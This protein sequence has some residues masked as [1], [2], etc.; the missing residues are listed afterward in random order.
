MPSYGR[1]DDDI[2]RQ[3]F[4]S[5]LFNGTSYKF[6]W[7]HIFV[8][9]VVIFPYISIFILF[10]IS[11]GAETIKVSF[12]LKISFLISYFFISFSNQNYYDAGFSISTD[13]GQVS[14]ATQTGVPLSFNSEGK[15]VEG[16]GT[17][18]YLNTL[19][20]KLEENCPKF[21]SLAT[22]YHGNVLLSSYSIGSSSSSSLS[23]TT[24]KSKLQTYVTSSE[25]TQSV[26][27]MTS[28]KSSLTL[29]NLDIL[30]VLSVPS[31][32]SDTVSVDGIFVTL[33][34]SDSTDEVL[35]NGFLTVGRIIKDQNYN[36]DYS[37][38]KSL[39]YSEDKTVSPSLIYLTTNK[40]LLSYYK[41][42]KKTR[43]N[44]KGIRNL[45]EDEEEAVFCIK[46]GEISS[47]DFS[48]TLSNEFEIF[49]LPYTSSNSIKFSYSLTKFSSSYLSLSYYDQ[50]K[51]QIISN[52]I[53]FSEEN[54]QILNYSDE[55][56]I[57]ID[58][59]TLQS[60]LQSTF[61]QANSL[62]LTFSSKNMIQ[63]QVVYFLENGTSEISL[64]FGS[65]LSISSYFPN[66][67]INYNQFSLFSLSGQGDFIILFPD[68]S[69][70]ET[71]SF[72]GELG[73]NNQLR[74]LAPNVDLSGST[75]S[76]TSP[77]SLSISSYNK[78]SYS[79]AS[80]ASISSTYLSSRTAI[81]SFLSNTDC[82]IESE[83]KF[84]VLDRLSGVVGLTTTFF[85]DGKSTI[86]VS[87]SGIVSKIE[88]KLESGKK[89][90]SNSRGEL[91]SSEDFYG[92][93]SEVIYDKESNS[94]LLEENV[95]GIATSD[96][97]LDVSLFKGRVAY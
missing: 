51:L 74:R 9:A 10:A 37:V 54:L 85:K 21:T 69:S 6:K 83:A 64:L 70:S 1:I 91:I 81:L 30:Q 57:K 43:N 76:L 50:S 39:S 72:L 90:Y 67:N 31:V 78:N 75:Y 19:N 27:S 44:Q 82:T 71:I 42:I 62:L 17:S 14:P 33:S 55:S 93:T 49:T 68:S 65:F 92:R 16:G 88:K 4:I 60:P 11:G 12:Y 59:I 25:K 22:L 36:I 34:T 94:V 46:F 48:L 53:K 15:L 35:T 95:V 63:S 26:S 87:V 24:S 32:S 29:D 38:D 79:T 96:S 40:I 13:F 97:E 89:Y 5:G 84:S 20:T 41:I 58:Q 8:I 80:I 3:G 66:Q 56:S 77:S 45:Q 52:F 2:E 47:T 28:I 7:W 23:T 86:G 73:L 18:Y 61:I